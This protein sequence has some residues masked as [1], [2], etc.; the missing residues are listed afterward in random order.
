MPDHRTHASRSVLVG[1]RISLV[2][3]ALAEV[4]PELGENLPRPA[5][6]RTNFTMGGP[7]DPGAERATE[8]E[9]SS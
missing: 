3:A 7:T 1:V 2:V 9:R 6:V 4:F 5:L 8:I